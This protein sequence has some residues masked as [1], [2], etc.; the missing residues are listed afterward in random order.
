MGET[1]A[2]SALSNKERAPLQQGSSEGSFADFLE[3]GGQ[4][5]KKITQPEDRK[6]QRIE[7]CEMF[8][9]NINLGFAFAVIYFDAL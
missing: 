4:S 5:I 3:G 8:C 6:K 2:F 9:S 7:K 1:A